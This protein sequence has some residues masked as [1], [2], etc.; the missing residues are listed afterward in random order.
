[1][2]SAFDHYGETCE[3]C[4]EGHYDETVDFDKEDNV[5][6]CV[7]CG[8]LIDRYELKDISE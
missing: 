6:R 7:V 4:H 5:L 8:H 1:M 3:R 2:D